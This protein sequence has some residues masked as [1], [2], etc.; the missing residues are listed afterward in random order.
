[1]LTIV[2]LVEA[3]FDA[4]GFDI[5]LD[6]FVDFSIKNLGAVLID[7]YLLKPWGLFY[8]GPQFFQSMST[9]VLKKLGNAI[10]T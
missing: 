5:N 8:L 4:V 10:I 7:V 2:N 9:S 1:M 3:A 6:Y